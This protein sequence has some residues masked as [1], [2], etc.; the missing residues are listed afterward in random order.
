MALQKHESSQTLAT[1]LQD[2]SERLPCLGVVTLSLIRDFRATKHILADV[3]PDPESSMRFYSRLLTNKR[4]VITNISTRAGFHIRGLTQDTSAFFG[5]GPL[6]RQSYSRCTRSNHRQISCCGCVWFPP[7]LKAKAEKREMRNCGWFVSSHFLKLNQ[8]SSEVLCMF[9]SV[10]YR[11]A[12][13]VCEVLLLRNMLQ[14][15]FSGCHPRNSTNRLFHLIVK[16]RCHFV[17]YILSLS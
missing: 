3:R 4:W 12:R 16:T 15:S 10:K 6:F 13:P 7:I 5:F 9:S 2:A 11:L 1:L 8:T 17:Q 14:S